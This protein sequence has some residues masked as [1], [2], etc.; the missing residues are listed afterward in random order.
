MIIVTISNYHERENDEKTDRESLNLS[1]MQKDSHDLYSEF[2]Q[3]KIASLRKRIEEINLDLE[4]RQSI[5]K[6]VVEEI[7]HQIFSASLFLD[8]LKHWQ[9]G[10]RVGVDMERNLWERQIAT[11]TKEK[12]HEMV[13]SWKDT[14]SLREQKRESLKEYEELWKR[15]N[16][17][18]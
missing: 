15:L 1:Q 6:N 4:S 10:Y 12:R 13:S 17:L 18:R 11:L 16:F 5:H 7:Y 2:F 8:R 9:I 14:L 3:S